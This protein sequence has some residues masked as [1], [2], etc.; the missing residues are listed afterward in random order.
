MDVVVM[1][2]GPIYA[3]RNKLS[4]L[5]WLLASV[6]VLVAGCAANVAQT[7]AATSLVQPANAQQTET[8]AGPVKIAL[9]LSLGGLGP[10]AAMSKAMK[11]A[12]ELALFERDDPN[13]QLI[14]KDDKGTEAGA[15]EAATLAVSEGAEI[16]IGPLLSTAVPGAARVGRQ[17][18]VPVIALSNNATAAG[19]NVYLISFLV[20]EEVERVV[21]YAAGRGKKHFAALIPE[22][23]YGTVAEAAFRQSVARAGGSIRVLERYPTY[24]NGMVKPVQSIATAM[25]RATEA[26]LPIDVLFVPGDPD[27]LPKLGPVLTYAGIQNGLQLVG[28]G[29]WDYTGIGREK[30]FVGGWFAGPDPA[31]FVTF[32]ER[33]T[34]TFGRKPPRLATL[35]YDAIGFSIS[36]SAAPPGQ[37]FTYQTLTRPS[38]Y[39]GVDGLIRLKPNGLPDRSLA[40][41]EVQPYGP[42]VIDMPATAAGGQQLSAIVP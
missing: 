33:F 37:R 9:L 8:S 24:A 19:P 3:S 16:I 6:M 25:K 18:Q 42:R 7:P 38:G 17:S 27:T 23:A 11:Q 28:T 29:S 41:L 31:T 20:E 15:A 14:V 21:S 30:A 4:F 1:M 12:A 13:I 32:S 36:L 10:S 35:A 40:V 22:T 5:L 34:R 2:N 39:F 26:G